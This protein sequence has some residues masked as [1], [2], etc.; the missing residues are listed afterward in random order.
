MRK[1]LVYMISYNNYLFFLAN[2]IYSSEFPKETSS[3]ANV[4]QTENI[5][6]QN[7]VTESTYNYAKYNTVNLLHTRRK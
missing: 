6:V 3:E 1:V 4:A 7:I 2:N 5:S